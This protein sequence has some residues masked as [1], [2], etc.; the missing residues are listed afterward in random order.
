MEPEALWALGEE[1][2]YEVHIGW[3]GVDAEGRYDVLFRRNT[4]ARA[5]R[6]IGFA[7]GRTTRR[8]PWSTYANNPLDREFAHGLVPALQR[9]LRQ[10]LPEYMVP[11]AFVV[12]DALPL[13]PNGKV[14]RLALPAP[15]QARPELEASY[16]APDNS[17][18]KLLA[19][20]WAQAL[21]LERVGIHD[22]FFALGGDSILSVQVIARAKQAG[23]QLTLNQ[24][25]QNQT[26]AGLAAVAGT[27]PTIQAD[28]G[29]VSGQVLLTPIQQWFFEQKF[30]E[31]HHSN[32][33]ILLEVQHALDPDLL[34][35]V[36]RHLLGHHDALRLRFTYGESGWQ[37]FH[38]VPEETPPFSQ[39]DLSALSEPAQS[40]QIEARAAAI[41][42]S[43]NLSEG[44]LLR[45]VLFDLGAS[46][47]SRL[48]LVIHHLVVDGVSWRILIEDFWAA[49]EQL[50][51]G[52][53]VQL[54][55]KTTSF[56]RWAQRLTEYARSEVL[57]PELDYW[58]AAPG[59]RLF[60][61]P[62]D[63]TGGSNTVASSRTV[64]V[65]LSAEET[66]ALLQEVP[67]AYRT[68]INE[69]LLTALAQ[70]YAKWTGAQSLLIDLE[71]HGREA[72]FDDVD[73]SRTVGWFTT[74]FPVRLELEEMILP[75]E[76]LK[77][78]KE[79]LR[80]IPN[81]GIGYGV[82]R[83]LSLDT[84]VAEKLQ[85]LPQA[86][87]NFNYLG[88][89]GYA[90]ADHS[91]VKAARES[92]GAMN[93]PR[94]HRCYLLELNASISQGQF[95]LDWMY[96]ENVHRRSTIEGLAQDFIEAL[97][98]L[99]AHCQSPEAGGYTPSDFS[100]AKLTQ[101]ALDRLIAKISQSSRRRSP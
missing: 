43:L 12:L 25:F 17:I 87:I 21:G 2:P 72:L 19:E 86:E 76:A 65:S 20:I 58:L 29:V 6:L 75:G 42:T 88:Q 46:K 73:V 53:G 45:V 59:T 32:Q 95:Q 7:T 94:A 84:Q 1:L 68:L 64:S 24:L 55:P 56:Q 38:A 47:P 51:R 5:S 33:A 83:Y 40:E 57:Q 28:Q 44:P 37:Q 70:A 62:T 36:V 66:R 18:E 77:S 63:Y 71:G 54:P 92:C 100:K 80:R 52:E 90:A 96:S 50:S 97:Q 89:F 23:L 93:S 79:Q 16:V 15:N 98:L 35:R 30:L 81:R 48:L 74:I 26:I 27:I 85:T 3:A 14:D 99:I 22:N 60:H 9:F 69:V 78:V 91:P 34:T 39:L 82:L 4:S 10:Q 11:S 31:S 61:L 8:E 101:K 13:M 49:Y 67:T 41:Q